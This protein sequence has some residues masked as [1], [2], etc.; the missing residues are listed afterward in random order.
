MPPGGVWPPGAMHLT[1]G[2]VEALGVRVVGVLE[3]VV[4]ARLSVYA[5]QV[6]PGRAVEFD[7]AEL[8]LVPV[9]AIFGGGVTPGPAPLFQGPGHVPHLEDFFLL[10]V[11]HRLA[12]DLHALVLAAVLALLPGV[13]CDHNGILGVLGGPVLVARDAA[14]F[15]DEQIVDKQLLP[16]ADVEEV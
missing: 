8:R 14:G 15:I 2:F 16:A 10:V 12:H 1:L 7:E 11:E 3:G 4:V 6:V 9:V 13:V 5:K